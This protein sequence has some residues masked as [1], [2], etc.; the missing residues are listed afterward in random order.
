VKKIV[1]KYGFISGLILVAMVYTMMAMMGDSNDF[2]KGEVIGYLFMIGGF[3]MIFLGIREYRDR[4]SGGAIT[5]TMGFRVGILITLVAS[6]CYV[7]GWMS[8]FHFIDGTFIEK[9][10]SYYIGKINTSGKSPAEIEKE[11]TAF[12]TNMENYKN[13]FVM[14]LYTFGEVFP[15]GLVITI[16]CAFLMRRKIN[17]DTVT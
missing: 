7:A 2:E 6:L 15:M 8:Y 13:P 16:L 14:A 3:S 1:I 9:Y 10:S 17:A 5:F 12:N 11:I 4:I